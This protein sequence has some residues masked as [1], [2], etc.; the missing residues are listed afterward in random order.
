[1][2]VRGHQQGRP[3]RGSLTDEE[4]L[5]VRLFAM[6]DEVQA[7]IARLDRGQE[8]DD[9]STLVVLERLRADLVAALRLATAEPDHEG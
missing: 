8:G 1:V 6:L 7:A 3:W 9:A 2:N 5:W 4:F